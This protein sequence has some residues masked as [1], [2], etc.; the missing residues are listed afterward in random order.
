MK[1]HG[2]NK[3]PYPTMPQNPSKYSWIRIVI[4]VVSK[5]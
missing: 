1:D 4:R 3:C 2:N 5:S